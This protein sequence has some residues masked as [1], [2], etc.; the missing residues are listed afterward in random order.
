MIGGTMAEQNSS[1][2]KNGHLFKVEILIEEATNG[3]AMETLLHLLNSDKVKDYRI[4]SGMNLGKLI[5]FNQKEQENA[6]KQSSTQPT[7]Q[8]TNKTFID[9]LEKFKK[10]NSLIR[11]TVVKGKG[12]KLSLP[13]RILNY[14]PTTESVT[15]YHVD[16]KK[17]Y[18]FKLNEIDDFVVG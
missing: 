6:S 17:V 9:Q 12:I 14:D 8:D 11:M 3:H 4:L 5:E 1:P 15:V 7:P 13:C 10:A 2:N 18:L 16:E